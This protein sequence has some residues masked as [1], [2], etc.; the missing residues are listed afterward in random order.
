MRYYTALSQASAAAIQIQIQRITD[1]QERRQRSGSNKF[2]TYPQLNELQNP[3]H[4][5]WN[6]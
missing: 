6:E 4:Y 3:I 5:S 1:K 2:H